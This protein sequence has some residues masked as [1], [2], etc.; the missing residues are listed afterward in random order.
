MIVGRFAVRTPYGQSGNLRDLKLVPSKWRS[1]IP[2]RWVEPV[3][4]TSGYP[5][6]ITRGRPRAVGQH[7][8]SHERYLLEKGTAHEYREYSRFTWLLLLGD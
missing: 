5:V 1:L 7:L 8:H 2:P 6:E 3:E 4:T